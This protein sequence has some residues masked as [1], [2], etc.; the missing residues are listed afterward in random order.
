MRL[1]Y[2]RVLVDKFPECFRFYK[3]TLGLEL[4]WGDENNVYAEFKTDGDAKIAI[5]KRELAEA[6]LRFKHEPGA[7]RRFI[8]VLEVDDVDAAVEEIEGRGEVATGAPVDRTE[9]GVR[10]AHF[11]DPDGNV[12]ELNT[13]LKNA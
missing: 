5:F 10:T 8:I 7:A 12:I 4:V 2:V 9:W 11:L 3:D 13:P 1:S 6:A